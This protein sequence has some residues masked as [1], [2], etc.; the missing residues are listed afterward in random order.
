VSAQTTAASVVATAS[1]A[2]FTSCTTSSEWETIATW[3]V[4]T[5]IV[6]APMRWAKRPLGVGWDRLV[7]VGD[8]VPG[9]ERLPGRDGHHLGQRRAGDWLLHRV[10]DLGFDG[11]DVGCEVLVE[12]V[13]GQPGKTLLVDVEVGERRAGWSLCEECADRFAFVLARSHGQEDG[14]PHIVKRVDHPMI[15][16]LPELVGYGVLSSGKLR[17]AAKE[18]APGEAALI[19]VGEPTLE[20]RFDKAV[21]RANK[22]AKESFKSMPMPTSSPPSS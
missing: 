9:G 18:L 21:T 14:K 6:V 7:A 20:K 11:V 2:V 10:H 5:S 17:D 16:V 1:A 12:V 4:A 13:F 22:V 8:E 19:V 15:D 3:F